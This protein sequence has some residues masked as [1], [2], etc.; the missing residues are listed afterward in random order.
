MGIGHIADISNHISF[1]ARC[2]VKTGHLGLGCWAMSR[3]S[4]FLAPP[5]PWPVWLDRELLQKRSEEQTCLAFWVIFS[6]ESQVQRISGHDGRFRMRGEQS[7]VLYRIYFEYWIFGPCGPVPVF[8]YCSI[9]SWKLHKHVKF[10]HNLGLGPQ[11]LLLLHRIL[12]GMH[13]IG[14]FVGT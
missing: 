4:I 6:C 5:I 14:D 9:F 11:I 7:V 8:F 1:F 10:S 13:K 12:S 2:F 3:S